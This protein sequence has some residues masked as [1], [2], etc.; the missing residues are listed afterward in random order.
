MNTLQKRNFGRTVLIALAA[1]GI[2]GAC[3]KDNPPVE[4]PVVGTGGNSGAGGRGGTNGRGGTSGADNPGGE[5]SGGS[6]GASGSGG[7]GGSGARGGA[8]GTGGTSGTGADGG[9]GN[10]GGDGGS[11]CVRNPTRPEDFLN[12]CTSS[13][14]SPFDN[15]ARIPRFNGTLPD[16]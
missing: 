3:G 8:A 10:E 11:D 4:A 9:T 16:L 1:A 6:G 2:A 5:S 13:R 15:F 14:C 7:K 12:R